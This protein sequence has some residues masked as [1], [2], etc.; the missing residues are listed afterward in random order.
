MVQLAGLSNAL[1]HEQFLYIDKFT[2]I[3]T[4]KDS[5]WSAKKGLPNL[6]KKPPFDEHYL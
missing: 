6:S 2:V 1:I 5:E 3:L 4:I